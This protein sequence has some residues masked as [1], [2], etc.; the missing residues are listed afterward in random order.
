MTCVCV[1]TRGAYERQKHPASAATTRQAI[2]LTRAS[3][4]PTMI[5]FHPGMDTVSRL[6][7]I[8]FEKLLESSPD[9]VVAVDRKGIIIFYNDGA[10]STLGYSPDEVLG[11]H[12]TCLY[13]DLGEARKVMTAMRD[14]YRTDTKGQVRNFETAFVSKSGGILPVA[15]SG[16]VIQTATGE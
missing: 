4:G 6:P 2:A 10:R 5:R 15:I 16:S 12:V 14:G 13:P 7:S 3:P 8:Y 9:I 1:R 11:Q